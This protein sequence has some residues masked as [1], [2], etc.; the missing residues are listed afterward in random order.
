MLTASSA[1]SFFEGFAFPSRC[2]LFFAIDAFAAFMEAPA[3][4][5]FTTG[6][7]SPFVKVSPAVFPVLILILP[8]SFSLYD[9]TG[10][11]AVIALT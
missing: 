3:V 6:F 8:D 9:P 1:I 10:S 11:A 2:N 7:N 5:K 4:G